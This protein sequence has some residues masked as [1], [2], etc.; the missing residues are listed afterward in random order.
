MT[1]YPF[2][3]HLERSDRRRIALA[4]PQRD[5]AFVAHSLDRVSAFHRLDAQVTENCS[6]LLVS[7]FNLEEQLSFLKSAIHQMELTNSFIADLTDG[8]FNV[9]FEFGVAIGLGLPVF[10][11]FEQDQ[12]LVQHICD[13]PLIRDIRQYRPKSIEQLAKSIKTFVLSNRPRNTDIT[14]TNPFELFKSAI[15]PSIDI[16]IYSSSY[17]SSFTQ[18]IEQ[19]LQDNCGTL[20]CGTFHGLH[21]DHPDAR[22]SFARVASSYA[23]IFEFAANS[24]SNAIEF[25]RD[26]CI[27]SGYSYGLGKKT[28]CCIP[29]SIAARV[30]DFRSN[31]IITEEFTNSIGEFARF[32]QTLSLQLSKAPQNRYIAAVKPT[33]CSNIGEVDNVGTAD[34]ENDPLLGY[35]ADKYFPIE[36]I[37]AYLARPIIVGKRGSGK[38]FMCK[39]L[40]ARLREDYHNNIL[41]ISSN[42][43][44]LRLLGSLLTSSSGLDRVRELRKSSLSKF[45]WELII[46]L[47][48]LRSLLSNL[49]TLPPSML[50]DY[51]DLLE[52]IDRLIGK[53]SPVGSIV[54]VFVQL[55]A[56]WDPDNID[57]SSER[58]LEPYKYLRESSEQMLVNLRMRGYNH[59][60]I[61]DSMDS[62]W[63]V[64]SAP[65][66]AFLLGLTE[67]SVG[68]ARRNEYHYRVV[69]SLRSYLYNAYRAR[70]DQDEFDKVPSRILEWQTEGLIALLERRLAAQLSYKHDGTA[71]A[72]LKQCFF[73]QG[74]RFEFLMSYF[75]GSIRPVPR[76]A[77]AMFNRAWDL[78]KLNTKNNRIGLDTLRSVAIQ[79]SKERCELIQREYGYTAPWIENVL[80][81]LGVL[82]RR[83]YDNEDSELII[84]LSELES[85]LAKVIEQEEVYSDRG[86]AIKNSG[87]KIRQVISSLCDY[88]II[89]IS[90]ELKSSES[91]VQSV[92]VSRL[93]GLA[94]TSVN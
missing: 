3:L 25:N 44:E 76:E 94:L 51:S 57:A 87:G 88:G 13:S 79:M 8:N 19:V 29:T 67:F 40:A 35:L 31:C 72:L 61:I 22:S 23:N 64:R 5:S 36:S 80:K 68:I 92:K 77:I 48:L 26:T 17:N 54:N 82:C 28:I 52:A 70:C 21:K 30:S 91:G 14:S 15:N 18:E 1:Q 73:T 6:A 7:P 69:L 9:Y 81:Q 78:V 12:A 20:D 37:D 93:Y 90:G 11:F 83:Y 16:T 47:F 63:N 84:P 62:L 41:Y 74:K 65:S 38:T 27:L 33:L 75:F 50:H 43:E 56:S 24:E 86:E 45:L 85:R 49:E 34:A 55:Y 32:V 39:V 46:P 71:T 2:L 53:R 60:V 10:F 58:A 42:D 66:L 4:S 89:C 59:V